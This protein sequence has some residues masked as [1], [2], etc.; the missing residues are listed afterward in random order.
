MPPFL[1]AI[2][3]KLTAKFAGKL[4]PA[5]LVT[6]VVLLGAVHLYLRGY[7][8]GEAKVKAEWQEERTLLQRQI[9]AYQARVRDIERHTQEKVHEIASQYTATEQAR[10][11]EL[12]AAAADAQRLRDEL[13]GARRRAAV[14]AARPEVDAPRLAR[15]FDECSQESIRL[16][17]ELG[18]EVIR[19]GGVADGLA[20]TVTALQDYAM[21]AQSL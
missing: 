20:A 16:Q 4:I 21:A 14:A 8:Q 12:A 2:G 19:L 11:D 7:A 13:A 1:A 18:A 5:L 9:I 15:A 6:G 10:Q 17:D 3:A